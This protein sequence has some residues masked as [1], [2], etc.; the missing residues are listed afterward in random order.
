MVEIQGS[1]IVV[2]VG[3]W[4]WFEFWKKQDWWAV[5]LGFFILLLGV[6]TI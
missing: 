2:G 1:Q 4:E 3:K 5:W 6:V